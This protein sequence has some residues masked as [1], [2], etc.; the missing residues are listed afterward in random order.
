MS[1][2][3]YAFILGRER[4]LCLAELNAVLDRFCFCNPERSRTGDITSVRENTVFINIAQNSDLSVGMLAEILGGTTKI[5]EIVGDLNHYERVISATLLEKGKAGGKIDFGISSFN[6]SFSMKKINEI[7]INIKKSLKGQLSC[8]FVALREGTE[9]STILSLKEK[10]IGKG[11]EFGFFG[12]SIGI[13][14]GLSNPIEWSTRDYEK[15]AGDKYSGMLPPKLARIMIN[16]AL[17]ASKKNNN[18]EFLISNQSPSPS[19]QNPEGLTLEILNSS[20]RPLVVDSFCGSG[21]VLMEALM[22]GC[23][24]FGSDNSEKAA[25]DAKANVQWL[26]Q[27]PNYKI[28]II[29]KNPNPKIQIQELDATSEELI[30]NLKL[31]I[32]N[33]DDILVVCE[34]YLGEPKK[35]KPSENSAR[36]EYR[37][38]EELYLKFFNNFTNFINLT[39]F[40]LPVVFCMVF[41]LVELENG[42][43][44]SL[45][46]ESVDEIAK[47]GYTE[48][49]Q[50]LIY[51]RE[52]QVVKREIALLKL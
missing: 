6:P 45:Y 32:R 37:K 44:Y 1:T 18:S 26:L 25:K 16:L 22:L 29:N 21:N 36:G 4:D 51:G 3:T 9:L 27:N 50:P 24:V 7:G 49:Q 47:I 23:D 19:V 20:L 30:R 10:L 17:G 12:K 52:Y 40:R 11:A 28:Q 5:F 2:K 15:P 33:Y 42:K 39:N 8:R 35:F 34:P 46:R 41:P 13:L 43:Q 14:V 48:L 31:E 38:I